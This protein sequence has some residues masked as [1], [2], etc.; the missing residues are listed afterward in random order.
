MYLDIEW[1]LRSLNEKSDYLSKIVEIE[2]LG[3]CPVGFLATRRA[4][5]TIYF[6]WTSL[7]I[8]HQFLRD[9]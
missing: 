9:G 7:L 6:A 4:L 1:L 3:A 2:R 5:G 8:I